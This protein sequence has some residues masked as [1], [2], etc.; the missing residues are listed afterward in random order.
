M[1]LNLNLV[2]FISRIFLFKF[3]VKYEFEKNIFLK[4]LKRSLIVIFVG[5]N[6]CI[7]SCL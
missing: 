3:L 7:L 5:Y 1:F 2:D 4:S 6:N